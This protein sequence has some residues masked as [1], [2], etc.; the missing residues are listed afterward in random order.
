MLFGTRRTPVESVRFKKKK[1]KNFVFA[2]IKFFLR[3]VFLY[4]KSTVKGFFSPQNNIFNKIVN[5]II[6]F[7]RT[8]WKF[9]FDKIVKNSILF[10]LPN[11]LSYVKIR[12]NFMNLQFSSVYCFVNKIITIELFWPPK[13]LYNSFLHFS[14]FGFRTEERNAENKKVKCKKVGNYRG[15]K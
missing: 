3:I 2:K 5:S 12:A 10:L 13:N 1:K 14:R 9:F 7:P 6:F 4:T 11:C 8:E 15:S